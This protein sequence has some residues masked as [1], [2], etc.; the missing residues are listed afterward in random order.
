[1]CRDCGLVFKTSERLLQHYKEDHKD[2]TMKKQV[3][4]LPNQKEAWIRFNIDRNPDFSKTLRY[5]FVCYADFESSNIPSLE[6][7]TEKTKI[8][9]RQIPNSYMLFCPDL[10]FLEDERKLSKDS[11]MKKFQNDDPYLVLAKFIDDLE[12]IRKTCIF[13]WQSHPRLPK[14]TKEEQEKYDAAQVCEKCK[15]PFDSVNSPKVRRHCHV[16]G[17]YVGAWC[18]RCNYLEGRKKLQLMVFFHNLRG[19]DA[20][21][22]L[23]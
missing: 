11:Y 23:R 6:M 2:E 4:K 3:L 13:R 21:M 16:T 9:M 20:H 15:K 12:T 18:R 17:K 10:L 5:F 22:I 19:Y 7:K 8:L 14:L 1:M